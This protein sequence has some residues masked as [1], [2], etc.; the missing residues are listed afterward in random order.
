MRLRWFP[1]RVPWRPLGMA[2][3]GL[4]CVVAGVVA[5]AGGAGVAGPLAVVALGVAVI[6]GAAVLLPLAEAGGA[7]LGPDRRSVLFPVAWTRTGALLAGA[8]GFTG[9]G[10]CL[11]ALG[12]HAPR[13]LPLVVLGVVT[14]LFF[15]LCGLVLVTRIAHGSPVT[16]SPEALRVGGPAGRAA[17]EWP[18]VV[19]VESVML[20]RRPHLRVCL[21]GRNDLFIPVDLLACPPSLL[22]RAVAYYAG[23]PDARADLA[24]GHVPPW[25]R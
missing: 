14:A 1:G 17:V 25:L 9:C 7:V 13:G 21:H 11:V 3:F 10:V 24:A 6:G 8:L 15:G 2:A 18:A 23:S 4:L 12:V 16:L 20:G 19:E 5:L 22:A